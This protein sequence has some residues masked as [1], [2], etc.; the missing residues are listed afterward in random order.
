MTIKC[1]KVH[2]LAAQILDM[3]PGTTRAMEEPTIRT[4]R[5][6]FRNYRDNEK[7]L[8][9]EQIAY[10]DPA[11]QNLIDVP[12]KLLNWA[13]ARGGIPQMVEH[14]AVRFTGFLHVKYVGAYT[15]YTESSDGSGLYINGKLI[16]NNDGIHGIKEQS[17]EMYMEPGYYRFEVIYFFTWGMS[18]KD[19]KYGGGTLDVLWQVST[20]GN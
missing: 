15:F 12:K 4:V 19:G 11:K 13:N 3:S 16:V 7:T 1:L 2:G 20:L 14:Y 8:S 9:V 18:R 5:R 17:G 6:K 10:T